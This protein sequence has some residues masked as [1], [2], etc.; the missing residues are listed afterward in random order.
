MQR[1]HLRRTYVSFRQIGNQN[2]T[3]AGIPLCR[4]RHIFSPTFSPCLVK[5]KHSPLPYP[6]TPTK[7]AFTV[8]FYPFYLSPILSIVS[9]LSPPP[10]SFAIFSLHIEYLLFVLLGSAVVNRLS[11]CTDLYSYVYEFGLHSVLV[12]A[13]FCKLV[14]KFIRMCF[15][16]LLFSWF[17]FITLY[18][19]KKLPHQTIRK[20]LLYYSI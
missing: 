14:S 13:A 7:P 18:P 1:R 11:I 17:I 3:K 20:F 10:L 6:L 15:S 16:M 9:Y 12:F 4:C 19:N 2:P 5:G 8:V